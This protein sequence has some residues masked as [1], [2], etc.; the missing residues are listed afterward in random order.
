MIGPVV[1]VDTAG[2]EAG[3]FAPVDIGA[4]SVRTVTIDPV[5]LTAAIEL[6]DDSID[7]A[8]DERSAL[9]AQ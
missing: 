5:N 7:V 1:A 9:L 8:S 3:D 2:G 6:S 4:N